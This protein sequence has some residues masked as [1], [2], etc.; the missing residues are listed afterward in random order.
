[1]E[2][3]ELICLALSVLRRLL[4]LSPDGAMSS[5]IALSLS[6]RPA[7]HTDRHLVTV[8]AQYI[9]HRHNPQLPSLA[10]KLLTALSVVSCVLCSH[11]ALVASYL[12]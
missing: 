6:A 2:L 4:Q 1:V 12:L 11:S 7:S 8:V 5:A 9:Y 3:I 10:T